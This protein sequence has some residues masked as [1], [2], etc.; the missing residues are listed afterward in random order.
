MKKYLIFVV[1]LLMI[2]C[3]A[4][5]P[6][7]DQRSPEDAAEAAA[8][9]NVTPSVI[10]ESPPEQR[11]TMPV[12][13]D[14]LRQKVIAQQEERI[15]DSLAHP[16]KF[17]PRNHTNEVGKLMADAAPSLQ[18]YQFRTSKGTFYV[19][20]GLVR[21]LLLTPLL[22]HNVQRD[23]VNY[24]ELYLDEIIVDRNAKTAKAYCFGFTDTTRK[25]CARIQ[26]A[27]LDFALPYDE[28]NPK[29]PED[30]ARE[31]ET[32]E[33][34]GSDEQKYYLNSVETTRLQ[35]LNGSEL[36]ILP[37]AGLPIK[38]V[39][40]PLDAITFDNFVINQVRPEDV[41]HR[42]KSDIPPQEPFYKTY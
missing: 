5:Q 38:V 11:E 3:T 19:R 28:A 37:K 32:K 36:Y 18:S 23:S 7:L 40:G 1:L 9:E 6:A 10:V 39:F 33:V 8:A 14:D 27:D 13:S 31:F 16:E 4:R 21:Y 17:T 15:E 25:Q 22:K 24:T 29:L 20:G 42:S 2:S 30:W 34:T 26:I 35:F 12:P 41:V